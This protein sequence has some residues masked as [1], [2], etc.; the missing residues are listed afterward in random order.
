M[1]K[2]K[3]TNKAVNDLTDIWNY[4]IEIWSEKQAEKYYT[5]LINACTELAQQPHIGKEYNEIHP[6]LK[7][8]KTSKHIIFYRIMEDKTIEIIR[9]L[10]EQMDLKN[11]LIK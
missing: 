9:I 5:L 4:T 7:G 1:A 11:K 2:F 8:Q 6:D 3:F 10:H